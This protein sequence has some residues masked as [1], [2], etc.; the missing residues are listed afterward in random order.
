MSQNAQQNYLTA[1]V[2]IEIPFHDCDPMNIVWHGHYAKYFEVARCALLNSFGYD[3][4]EMEASGYSWPVVEMKTKYVASARFTQ[5]ITVVASLVEYEHRLK[6]AYLITDKQS[7]QKL[8]KGST[9][10]A[11]V[12]MKTNIL[13]LESPGILIERLEPHLASAGLNHVV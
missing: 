12:D 11:A 9:I 1:S 8:T 2:D 4:L 5:V 7:G 3:Y 6:I 13:Q 10:Q